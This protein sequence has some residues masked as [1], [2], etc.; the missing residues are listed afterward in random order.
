M[1]M[2]LRVLLRK[3]PVVRTSSSTS[4]G[5]A[6]ARSSGRGYLANRAGVTMFTRSSVV[7]ADRMVA[8]SSS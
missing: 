1:P 8:V 3:K 4:A 6:A 7:W 5:S 2:M